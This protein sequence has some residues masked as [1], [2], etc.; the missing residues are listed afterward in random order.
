MFQEPTLENFRKAMQGTTG[1]HNYIDFKEK[2]VEKSKLAKGI[3]AIANSG[4]GLLV[5]SVKEM[6]D[7]T[8]SYDGI[9]I[10]LFN[11]NWINW[12]H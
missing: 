3:L 2:W 11:R 12:K 10:S 5:F 9:S 4:G 8:F 7:K 6:S 1:E